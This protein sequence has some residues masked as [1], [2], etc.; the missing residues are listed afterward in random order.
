MRFRATLIIVALAVGTAAAQPPRPSA[1]QSPRAPMLGPTTV[2]WE[3]IQARGPADAR[4]RQVFRN[5]T[6]TLDELEIHVTTL[7]PG[8]A[9]HAPHKHADEE[10]VIVKEGTLEAM[11]EG[12][13]RKLGPGSVIFEASNQMHGLRNAGDTPAIY[14]VIRW[15]S[16]AT[17][18]SKTN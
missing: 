4:A 7:P 14:Y 18:R 13:T 1:A 8:Q 17:P 5:P 11:V 2:S 3:E 15:T 10:I 6:A 16:P 12:Q 9:S